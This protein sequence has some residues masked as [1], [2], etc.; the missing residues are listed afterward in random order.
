MRIVGAVR[1]DLLQAEA[2]DHEGQVLVPE[3]GH[4][5]VA[6][7]IFTGPHRVFDA[8]LGLEIDP[9]VHALDRRAYT[10]GAELD[11]A[12]RS[13]ERREGTG[14]SVRVDI[15]GGRIIKTKKKKE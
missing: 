1:I 10:A 5:H 13:E 9:D 12:E 11:D 3:R 14:G 15:G 8:E 2:I 6:P 4:A 7:E